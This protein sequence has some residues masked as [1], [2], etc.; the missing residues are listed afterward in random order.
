MKQVDYQKLSEQYASFLVAVGGVSITVL[1]LVLS[2]GKSERSDLTEYLVVA[3]LVATVSCFIGSQMMAE[4]SASI[5]YYRGM[6]R[7]EKP[8]NDTP[9]GERLFLIASINIFISVLLVAFASMLLPTVSG[10]AHLVKIKPVAILIFSLVFIGALIWLILAAIYRMRPPKRRCAIFLIVAGTALVGF[11][12]WL[13]SYL[14]LLRVVFTLITLFSAA[15]L[16]YFAWTFKDAGRAN[17][18]DICFFTAAVMFSYASL[19]VVS[20]KAMWT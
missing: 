9:S 17:K 8:I 6:K 7:G 1:A 12:I 19:V 10:M 14:W 2:L 18:Y 3:L 16:V 13:P 5:I 20:F 15:S 11:L 4:T